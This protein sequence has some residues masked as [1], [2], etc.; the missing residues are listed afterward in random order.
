MSL[1]HSRGPGRQQL[2]P[3]N[4]RGLGTRKGIRYLKEFGASAISGPIKFTTGLYSMHSTNEEPCAPSPSPTEQPRFLAACAD[5]SRYYGATP[6]HFAV[7]NGHLDIAEYLVKNGALLDIPDSYG[8]TAEMVAM[9]R[10]DARITHLLQLGHKKK[11]RF[12]IAVDTVA[13]NGYGY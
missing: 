1:Q 3:Q 4:Q 6:L 13:S 7:A 12:Q 9:A 8:N 2:S 11:P 10:H 5:G